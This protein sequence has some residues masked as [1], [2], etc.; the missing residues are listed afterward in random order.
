VSNTCNVP[1]PQVIND[2]TGAAA[3][4]ADLSMHA[5][6]GTSLA[7]SS[8]SSSAAASSESSSASAAAAAAVAARTHPHTH[9]SICVNRLGPLLLLVATPHPPQHARVVSRVT[10]FTHA[11]HVASHV[12]RCI[13]RHT[14]HHTSHVTRCITRH[15]SHVTRCITR[16][17]SHVTPSSGTPTCRTAAP[18][19]QTR[20]Q[21]T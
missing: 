16:H 13:T 6:M 7:A 4:A 3:L 18:Q 14:L 19:P 15:T 5:R 1:P 10:R 21:V 17:T 12:T 20:A 11:P 9:R 2:Y 8:S